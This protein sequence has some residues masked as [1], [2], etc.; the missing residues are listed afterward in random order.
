MSVPATTDR[1]AQTLLVVTL[2]AAASIT[3]ALTRSFHA[4]KNG[5]RPAEALLAGA[6]AFAG[7]LTLALS[8]LDAL[9]L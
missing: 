1:Q 9:G 6:S 8:L 4:W 5:A 2:C 3:V 7:T